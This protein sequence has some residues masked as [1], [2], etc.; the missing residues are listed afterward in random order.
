MAARDPCFL[1]RRRVGGGMGMVANP[2]G[3]LGFYSDRFERSSQLVPIGA[4]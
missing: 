4:V 2:N 1:D 3:G